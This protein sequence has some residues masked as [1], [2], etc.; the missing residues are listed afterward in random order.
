M[1]MSSKPSAICWKMPPVVTTTPG[2]RSIAS[3]LACTSI[4][5]ARASSAV[6]APV[7]LAD[8]AV[9]AADRNRPLLHAD[10]GKLSKRCGPGGT[11][12]LK[13][14]QSLD[15]VHAAA[16]QHHARGPSSYLHLR[17]RAA[18]R[19]WLT[20]SATSLADSPKPAAAAGSTSISTWSLPPSRRW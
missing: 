11:S 13:L 3:T 8:S 20:W 6:R 5:M 19:V 2:G 9:R 1:K 7:I 12:Y 15:A 18:P 14:S 10:L 4:P 17:D 16:P